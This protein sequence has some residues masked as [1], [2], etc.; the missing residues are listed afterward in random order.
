VKH[1]GTLI[2][3]AVRLEKKLEKLRMQQFDIYDLLDHCPTPLKFS[4]VIL[5]GK[6]DA[7][8]VE[9]LTHAGTSSRIAIAASRQSGKS[10]VTGLFVAWC[11]VFI[12]GFQCLVA[13]RSLRQA[14]HYLTLV[15]QTVM[16]LI[17]REAM[18]QLNR[19]SLELPN[20]SQVLC[21]PCAQPDAGRG[22]S[23]H[24]VVIDEAAFAPEELFRAISPSVAATQGAIH[25]LSSPNGRQGYFFEAF[26]GLAQDVFRAFRVSWK[27]CPRIS[28]EIAEMERIALGDLYFRQ[29][30]EAQFI[31]PQGAFFGHA[32]IMSF[33]DEEEVPIEDLELAEIDALVDRIMPEPQPSVETLQRAYSRTQ[34]VRELLID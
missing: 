15:R 16:T 4:E 34:R 11:L 26:E 1:P 7:W 3:E 22:F 21:I 33:A 12:P 6:M 2:G 27:D 31:T 28:E 19:L 32:G 17:P 13:S 14:A 5:N 24:L 23:P 30:F 10:T 8:Q 18:V 29:E 9:Y 20:G 25:M